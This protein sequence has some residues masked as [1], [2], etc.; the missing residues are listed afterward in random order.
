MFVLL[1]QQASSHQSLLLAQVNFGGFVIMGEEHHEESF[2]LLPRRFLL[3]LH[4]H[5]KAP[6]EQSSLTFTVFQIHVA[7]THHH[8]QRLLSAHAF[9]E[10]YSFASQHQIDPSIVFHRHIQFLM[11][12]W[13]DSTTQTSQNRWA[14]APSADCSSLFAVLTKAPSSLFAFTL[15]RDVIPSRATLATLLS[16]CVTQ[17]QVRHETDQTVSLLALKYRLYSLLLARG[18]PATAETWR[19]DA[20]GWRNV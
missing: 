7:T 2:Q 1:H 12:S 18:L 9:T 6:P 19:V 13:A 11:S 5:V 3:S 8:L 4:R 17:L 20:P 15:T 16:F 10:A 14:T